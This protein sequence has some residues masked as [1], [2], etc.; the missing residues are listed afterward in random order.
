MQSFYSRPCLNAKDAA[1]KLETPTTSHANPAPYEKSVWENFDCA[2]LD[3]F[4]LGRARPDKEPRAGWLEDSPTLRHGRRKDQPSTWA[5]QSPLAARDPLKRHC[6]HPAFGESVCGHSS[7]GSGSGSG[8]GTGN[9]TGNEIGND[10]GNDG[11][12]DGS[13]SLTRSRRIRKRLA[14]GRGY[15]MTLPASQ[16]VALGLPR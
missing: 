2:G 6:R 3:G 1:G 5:I 12:N 13:L 7:S 8:S 9:D 4:P 10:T 11:G 16:W 15:R 14:Q